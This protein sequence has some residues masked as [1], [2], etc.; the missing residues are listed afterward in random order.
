MCHS[1][2]A[3]AQKD[4]VTLIPLPPPILANVEIRNRIHTYQ[5]FRAATAKLAWFLHTEGIGLKMGAEALSTW[6]GGHSG[7]CAQ[8]DVESWGGGCLRICHLPAEMEAWAR[9]PWRE[10][11]AP[12]TGY[13]PGQGCRLHS[14]RCSMSWAWHGAPLG[15]S[16]QLRWHLL[17]PPPQGAEQWLQADHGPRTGHSRCG[18]LRDPLTQV[19]WTGCAERARALSHGEQSL[20]SP[21]MPITLTCL[22]QA[23]PQCPVPLLGHRW[24]AYQVLQSSCTTSAGASTQEALGLGRPQRQEEMGTQHPSCTSWPRGQWQPVGRGGRQ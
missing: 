13:S 19:L 15:P 11:Q 6:P 12:T 4:P 9:Q 22:P 7:G 24:T 3:G 23:S 1:A 14:C 20:R 16:L 8:S 5:P 17:V 21:A 2:V 10:G 18:H